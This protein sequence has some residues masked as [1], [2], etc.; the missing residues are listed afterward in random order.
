M[1]PPGMVQQHAPQL[2]CR[3]GVE[4]SA[5]VPRR[6]LATEDPQIGFVQNGGGLQGVPGVLAAH[7]A[8][9]NPMQIIVD[10]LHKSIRSF[11]VAQAPAIQ[12]A[13]VISFASRDLP[14]ISTGLD[15][16]LFSHSAA[17]SSSR[18]WVRTNDARRTES[19]P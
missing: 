13:F 11:G 12:Q 19:H 7:F 16:E 15:Y 2:P 3:H 14:G 9:R 17:L 6:R 4:M 1:R 5:I 8:R 10:Q 18:G